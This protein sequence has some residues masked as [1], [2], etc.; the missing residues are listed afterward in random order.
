MSA[1][2]GVNCGQLRNLENEGL[3]GNPRGPRIL[4]VTDRGRRSGGLDS[5]GV[6][7]DAASYSQRML[8]LGDHAIVGRLSDRPAVTVARGRGKRGASRIHSPVGLPGP[9]QRSVQKP[10]HAGLNQWWA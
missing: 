3:L 4:V 1:A 8:Q 9:L 10:V 2:Q 5:K 7:P 6:A